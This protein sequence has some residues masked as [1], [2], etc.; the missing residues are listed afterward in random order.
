MTNKNT[1]LQ[2]IITLSGDIGGT[3]TRLQ[4]TRFNG[5]DKP[6]VLAV[7]QYRNS[8]FSRFRDIVSTFVTTH[9]HNIDA[10]C[11]AVA[12]PVT[13]GM[14][15]LTNLPWHFS[16]QQLATL[17]KIKRV[18]FINDFEAI[19]YGAPLLEA[20]DYCE[21]QTGIPRTNALQAII[22][23]GTGLGVALIDG[24]NGHTRVFATEGGHVDFSPA[25]ETQQNLLLFLR[26]RFH[27]VSSE[28]VVS[29]KGIENIYKYISQTTEYAI[30]ENDAL[31]HLS[32]FSRNFAA[33]ITRFALEHDDPIALHTLDTFIKCYGTVTGN[34]ALTSLPFG[35]L[36]IAGGIAPKLLPQMQDGRFMQAFADKGR[37]SNLLH[38]IPVKIIL[39]TK[40]GLIGAA[41]YAAYLI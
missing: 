27:R 30:H 32:H 22:G 19:G 9:D 35:G 13:D 16:E 12:G 3:K 25:D 6:E 41:Y 38:D 24:T 17:L 21:L 28:R 15:T 26:K 2:P 1:N 33:E 39:N 5:K 11:M 34:L 7:E 40:V 29:G 31:K 4:L 18:K 10:A 20:D 14:V 23:A 37:M 36:Y 8:E